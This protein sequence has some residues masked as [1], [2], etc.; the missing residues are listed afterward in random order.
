M[1]SLGRPRGLKGEISFVWHGATPLAPDDDIWL[2]T[3]GG[4]PEKR[5]V[6]TV[7]SH[8]SRQYLTLNGVADRTEAEKLTG[9]PLV[10]SRASLPPP[11]ADEAYLH[12]LI[13]CGVFLPDGTRVGRLDHVE[14]PANRE[15]W[16]IA[17]DNGSEILFPALPDFIDSFDL[18][19]LRVII[20]P[21]PGLL[22]VYNA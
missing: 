16:V 2:L 12:D 9:V 8:N 19:A 17:A 3:P 11:E 18:G 1:G 14:F 5:K 13:G 6:L 4:E 10:A 7:A 15:V 20:S 22:D 21:P